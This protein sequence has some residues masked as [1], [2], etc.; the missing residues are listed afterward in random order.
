ML[1]DN[2]NPY[3][4]VWPEILQLGW[5]DFECGLSAGNEQALGQVAEWAVFAYM[6]A[7]CNLAEP[8]FDD[9]L[10]MK[11][12]GS[13]ED[14][15]A[16]ALFD[17]PLLADSFFSRLNAG[18]RLAEDIVLRFNE[19]RTSEA[20]TLT[21][22]LRVASAYP[23]KRRMLLLSGHGM[24]WRGALV[25]ENIGMRYRREPARLRLPGPGTECDARLHNCLQRVQERLNREL[26]KPAATRLRYDVL[27]FDACYMGNIE[28]I[29]PLAGEADFLVVS[30]DMMPGEGLAYGSILTELHRNPTKSPAQLAE[31]I[32]SATNCFY[33][34]AGPP[35]RRI[36]LAA[37]EAEQLASFGDAFVRLA[38][39]LDPTVPASLAAVRYAM[40]KAWA[41][42]A[43]GTIDL[44][45]FV[46][47]LLERPLPPTAKEAATAVLDRWS[48]LVVTF[49]GGSTPDTTNGLSVYA[50]PA[51]EFDIAY[52]QSS[53]QL[54]LNFGIWAWFLGA[55]Y[56]QA[57]GA[58]APQHPLI[59]ALQ[60]TMQDLM[61]RGIYKP[62]DG[63]AAK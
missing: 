25:D 49:A 21:M 27:G 24:G 45:G 2:G 20:A 56:L 16:L 44:K 48:E 54:P 6:A 52:I 22:A 63:A 34:S 12:V 42:A 3:R 17:G 33:E 57:L 28:A 8:M 23:A 47:K 59:D 7:D 14:I 53:N 39:A 62:E 11:K 15:H 31:Y 61:A 10:E 55:Y 5:D 37:L 19:L 13:S 40:E 58:E 41:F 51:A 9:L 26:E 43:T 50:P 35:A 60:R 36:T 38:Q 29:A 30:E 1:L 32:V 18:T 46:L 4:G